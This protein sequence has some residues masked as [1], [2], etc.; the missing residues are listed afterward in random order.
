[1]ENEKRLVNWKST[2]IISIFAGWIGADRFYMGQPGL[3]IL[4]L[5]TFGFGGCWWL[6]DIALI[7]G[8]YQFANLTWEI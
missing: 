4:K 5:I 3:G 2:L 1:M 6:I 7:A 8:K